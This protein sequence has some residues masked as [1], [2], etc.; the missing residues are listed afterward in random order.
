MKRVAIVTGGASGIGRA[1]VELLSARDVDA[2]AFD[3]TGDDPVDVS[4]AVAVG[5]G[6]EHVRRTRGPIDI[7]VNA[8]GVAAGVMPFLTLTIAYSF[9]A[10]AHFTLPKES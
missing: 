9:V 8:A 3:V 2:V 10:V 5:R 7:L 1:T 6:V 4:D